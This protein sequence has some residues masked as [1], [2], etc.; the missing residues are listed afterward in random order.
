MSHKDKLFDLA[1]Q[2]GFR[3]TEGSDRIILE[4]VACLLNHQKIGLCTIEK[5]F[6]SVD[7]APTS[8]IGGDIHAARIVFPPETTPC[9]YQADGHPLGNIINT[10]PDSVSWIEISIKRGTAE[11]PKNDP[12][13]WH[14]VH[15]YAKHIIGAVKAHG[16][17]KHR[18][19]APQE[20]FRIPNTF[21]YRAGVG[22]MQEQIR[23]QHIA[24]IGLGGTG[25]YVLD[26][27][28]KTPVAMIHLCDD[29]EMDW[30]NF[31]RAP[32]APTQNEIDFQRNGLPKKVIY[33]Y[34]KYAPFRNNI[35]P[36]ILRASDT[37]KFTAFLSKH[38]IN[39]A[40]V[41]IDQHQEGDAARQDEVYEALFKAKIPFIDSGI[42]LTLNNNQIKGAITTSSYKPGNSDWRWAIPNAQVAG[43][44][45]GYRN[46]QL[47]EV[48]A[49]AATLALMEWRRLT[50][51]YVKNT[52]SFLHKFRLENAHVIWA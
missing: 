12:T 7:K 5:S 33:Y 29:D 18:P 41:N 45:L 38:V 32:G 31:M 49:L 11:N 13:V 1:Q 15:R 44:H 37:A 34:N 26:I 21:E 30:H 14:L 39:F 4:G 28:A 23:N 27:L 22:P 8:T 19:A 47:P 50:K 3:V 6:N 9:I 16:Q 51:Q 36:H 2:E 35:C 42:S 20:V 48:N 24:I 10:A 43:N 40:F 46:I 17:Q 25:S 52:Q